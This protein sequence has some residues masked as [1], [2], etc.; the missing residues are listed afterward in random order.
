[1]RFPRCV[2]PAAIAL[3]GT[4]ACS[5]DRALQPVPH[6]RA[7][8]V[9]ASLGSRVQALCPAPPAGLVAWWRGDGDATDVAGGFTGTLVGG[10]T[11]A[12]GKVGN[13]FEFDGVDDGVD[14]GTHAALDV[15]PGAGF[16]LAA[17][18]YPNGMGS[19][20]FDAGPIFEYFAGVRLWSIFS[21]QL[22]GW[23]WS[24][25]N[26]QLF[27]TAGLTS[28]AW[29]HVALTYQRSTGEARLYVQGTQGANLIV[30]SPFATNTSLHL[31]RRP[32]GSY[33]LAVGSLKGRIDDAQV[34]NRTLT[35][36]EIQTLYNSGVSGA[37]QLHA[38]AGAVVNAVEG[39][40]AAFDGSASTGQASASYGWDFGD[41]SGPG[42]GATP[43]HVYADNGTFPVTLT[44]T[45]GLL[46]ST[47]TTTAAIANATPVPTLTLQTVP[48]I[49]K[50]QPFVVRA[51]FS[52]KG[53]SDAPWQYRFFRDAIL[54]QQGTKGTQ[55][56]PGA[57][58]AVT[59]TI[60]AVGSH[61]LRLDITD[62]DGATGTVSLPVQVVP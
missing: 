51:G 29:N 49:H 5:P 26:G 4:M 55:P 37:C 35:A 60:N 13:A 27:T 22:G 8:A 12:A 18:I 15:G 46:V 59:L 57:T 23:F 43:S 11:F 58:Q 50:G 62:K 54:L 41:G 14:I 38:D 32:L 6:S 42:T 9:D 40:S 16:T 30:T 47:A 48:P 21:N 28:Q 10:T 3:M 44:M 34:Y 19:T 61:V 24:G 36:S 45:D 2:V 7:A 25:N 39:A 52:D 53:T 1:M 33:P 31:G 20:G 17:W 56:P